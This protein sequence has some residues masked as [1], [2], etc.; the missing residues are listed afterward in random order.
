MD[1]L[2]NVL[3]HT[4]IGDTELCESELLAP[5]G[6]EIA[7]D[8]KT[9]VHLVRRGVAWLR[10]DGRREPIRL[11]PGDLVL[12]A[13]GLRHT[14]THEPNAT[15]R[16]WSEE[17]G[18]MRQ[19]VKARRGQPSLDSTVLL[20]CSY[21][22]EQAG[23][24]PLLALLPSLIQMNVNEC[25]ILQGLV[26]LLLHE[27][28][29]KRPGAEIVVPRLVDSLLVFV[30]RRWLDAQPV[31]AAG[32]FG[33]LRDPPIGHALGLI[34]GNPQHPW[35]VEMLARRVALSRAAFAR[36]FVDLVGEPPLKYLTRW[37]MS[38]AAR[39]LKTTT[40]SVENVAEKVG[41][42]SS[43]AF[44]KAFQRHLRVSPGRYRT[45]NRGDR[46]ASAG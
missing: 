32:W 37:R 44:G 38:L 5:W 45:L 46:A 24:H 17:L 3:G 11:G 21:Q 16:L 41:Y 4:Q 33:A 25:D 36:R 23:Q 34:H 27:S 18:L 35:T 2:A 29:P 9:V 31:G 14:L 19:R 26:R 8:T 42:D 1:V 22:F 43:T 6:L 20:C 7:A 15:A 10:L 39:I 40:E 12:V 28:G 13:R 30:L